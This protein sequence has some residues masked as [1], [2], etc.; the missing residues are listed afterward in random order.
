MDFITKNGKKIPVGNKKVLPSKTTY[1]KPE[2]LDRY[3]YENL[4]KS[5]FQKQQQNARFAF[6]KKEKKE[7]RTSPKTDSELGAMK[8]LQGANQIEGQKYR[9]RKR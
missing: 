6:D 2:T 1:S 8:V 5:D 3:E 9:L 4:P 7:R